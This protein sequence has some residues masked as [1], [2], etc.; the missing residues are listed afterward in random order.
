MYAAYSASPS[1]D[2]T[3]VSDALYTGWLSDL[4]GRYRTAQHGGVAF[5]ELGNEPSLWNSRRVEGSD[6]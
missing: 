4:K 3:P 6:A 2:G 1:R 5:Y